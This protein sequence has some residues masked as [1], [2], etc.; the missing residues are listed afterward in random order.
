[1]RSLVGVM[2]DIVSHRVCWKRTASRTR[3]R[4]S[5]CA[6][7]YSLVEDR[8]CWPEEAG[9]E[10]QKASCAAVEE[11]RGSW[12]YRPCPSGYEPKFRH[13]RQTCAGRFHVNAPLMCGDARGAVALAITEMAAQAVF[14]VA[15]VDG[16]A[17]L[18]RDAGL[19]LAGSMTTVVEAFADMAKPFGHP[20]CPEVTAWGL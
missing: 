9:A 4:P 1:V 7:G 8:W 14:A 13:C 2:R 15:T 10:L 18:V 12:C 20:K 6:P 17:Q 19:L 16:L 5:A 3:S 11:K